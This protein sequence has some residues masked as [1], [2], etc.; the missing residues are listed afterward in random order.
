MIVDN[1][2]SSGKIEKKHFRFLTLAERLCRDIVEP[3]ARTRMAAVLA[4]KN[5]HYFLGQN[6]MKSHPF[7]ARFRKNDDAIYLHAEAVAIYNAL[8]SMGEDELSGAKTTLYVLRL[9]HFDSK[10]KKLVWGMAQPCDGCMAA[11]E[12][13]KIKQVFFSLD[14]NIDEPN[15]EFWNRR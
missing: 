12:T 15:F 14:S 13:F 6:V 2:K 7:A 1:L 11:I 3:V 5:Q 4:I 8:R 10:S 9:K